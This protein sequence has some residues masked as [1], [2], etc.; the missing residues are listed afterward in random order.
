MIIPG[1]HRVSPTREVTPE[2]LLAGEFD[3]EAG[4]KLEVRHL[5]LPPGSMVYLNARM[6]H[7]VE[8]KPLN[9][10]QEYRLFVIDIF[11]EVGPPHRHTQEI[12]PEWMEQANPERKKMFQRAPYS[13]ECW[14]ET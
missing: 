4:R 8:P 7:G 13:P 9:S 14:L 6:F 10:L 5:E 11:K 2:K 12:P 1:S 3:D